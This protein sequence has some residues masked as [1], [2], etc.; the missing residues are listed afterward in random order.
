[1]SLLPE[2]NRAGSDFVN[3]GRETT[4]MRNAQ[5]HD[6]EAAV[7]YRYSKASQEVETALCCPV[8]YDPRYLEAIPPEVLERDYGC[9]DPTPFLRSGETVLDLGSGVAVHGL[10]VTNLRTIAQFPPAMGP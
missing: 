8:N 4:T 10:W 7:W 5:L 9:G 1:M 2:N 6:P 3:D